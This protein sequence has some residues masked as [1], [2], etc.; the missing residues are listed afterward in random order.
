MSS[1]HGT[2]PAVPATQESGR[3]APRARRLVRLRRLKEAG[4]VLA[5]QLVLLAALLA[6]MLLASC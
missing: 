6:G 4:V 1:V 3:A 5:T 2:S